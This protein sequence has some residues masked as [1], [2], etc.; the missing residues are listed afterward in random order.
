MSDYPVVDA[1]DLRE[2]WYWWRDTRDPRALWR[3]RKPFRWRDVTKNDDLVVCDLWT[4]NELVPPAD[5]GGEWRGP[6]PEPQERKPVE[7]KAG[8]ALYWG[9][10]GELVK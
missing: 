7:I 3:A 6:I 2:G 10:N 1:K 9:P 4:K 8:D 5:L